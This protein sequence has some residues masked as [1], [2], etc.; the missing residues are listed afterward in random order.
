MGRRKLMDALD[1]IKEIDLRDLLPAGTDMGLS[2]T[3]RCMLPGHSDR[4]ASFKFHPENNSFFCWGCKK[5]GSVIDFWMALQGMDF[6]T[7]LRDLADR[8]RIELTPLTPEQEQR[9]LTDRRR[10][11]A[12]SFACT[13]YAEQL[14]PGSEQWTY[15]LGRGWS[16]ETIRDVRL[17]WAGKTLYHYISRY[18]QKLAEAGVTEGDLIEA[19]ILRRDEGDGHLY[20]HLRNR[21]VFPLL[22][23]SRVVGMSGRAFNDQA[24]LD[25]GRKYVN[26]A[27]SVPVLYLEDNIRTETYL[28]EG[29]PDTVTLHQLGLAAVGLPGTSGVASHVQKFARCRRV[30]LCFDTDAAGKKATA[31]NGKLIQAALHQGE[32]RVLMLPEQYKDLNEWILA[33]GKREDVLQLASN[34]PPLLDWLMGRVPEGL[35]PLDRE[36]AIA[37][38]LA[39]V[40]PMGPLQRGIALDAIKGRFKVKTADLAKMLKKIEGQAQA[41]EADQEPSG[42]VIKYEARRERIP[43]QCYTFNSP[44]VGNM[45][46]YLPVE[47]TKS[48]DDGEPITQESWESA[49]ITVTHDKGAMEIRAD[50]TR[51]IALSDTERSRIPFES[52]IKG[53]WRI[54]GEHAHGLRRF[55]AGQV[56]QLNGWDLFSS[57]REVFTTYSLISPAGD[58]DL[59]TLFA[60]QSYVYQLVDAIGYLHLTGVKQSGKSNIANLLDFLCFNSS[61]S[62]NQTGAVLFRGLE[63]TCGVRIMEEAERLA[64]P[65]PGTPDYD[66]ML[67]MNDGYKRGGRAERMRETGGKDSA[68]GFEIQAFDIYGP[69]VLVG[70]NELDDV[71]ASRCITILCQ[72]ASRQDLRDANIKDLT[73]RWRREHV[74]VAELRD[75]LHVWALQN[76]P[77]VHDAYDSLDE[78]PDLDHLTSRQRE[79]WLPLLALARHVDSQHALKLAGGD[80]VAAEAIFQGWYD[81]WKQ[82]PADEAMVFGRMVALQREKEVMVRNNESEQSLDIATLKSIHRLI[83]EDELRPSKQ[84]ISKGPIFAINDMAKLVTLDLVDAGIL[85]RERAMSGRKL[86]AILYK[87]GAANHSEHFTDFNGIDPESGKRRTIRGLALAPVSLKKT[88]ERLG[89]VISTPA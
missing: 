55:I 50:L 83:T 14:K 9:V 77:D 44:A 39:L 62:S 21:I 66:L 84:D 51:D 71:L 72:R 49:I 56:P 30:Y 8:Y 57:I 73:Q 26:L 37:D 58:Y 35:S 20:E 38:L 46:A 65:K 87:T 70:I 1:R 60:M 47:R 48:N 12:L 54:E 18:P 33:G 24:A 61:K 34:A 19:G 78:D 23:R 29:L 5:G 68:K 75:Q 11:A 64:N 25:A 13:Y 69:K 40:V 52:S 67:M 85:P 45:V 42:A 15:L 28:C 4:T 88:V 53:R 31:V 43:A 22:K 2:N 10:E 76:F 41:K 80:E 59:I 17:G 86:T 36:G 32:V 16:E 63:S 74:R 27:S 89:G 6:V 7:A 3:V 81:A 79:M 82:D